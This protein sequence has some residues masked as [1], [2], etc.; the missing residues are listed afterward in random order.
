MD[1][2]IDY[3]AQMFSLYNLRADSALTHTHTHTHTHKETYWPC[4]YIWTHTHI[5]RHKHWLSFA[6][7]IRHIHTC[8]SAFSLLGWM[9]SD[10][11]IHNASC[12]IHSINKDDRSVSFFRGGGWVGGSSWCINILPK[13]HI[14]SSERHW[15]ATQHNFVVRSGYYS[16]LSGI[17]S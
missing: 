3:L 10:A 9:M 6:G 4:S 14:H 11:V 13:Y 7:T 1:D 15:Y 16:E 17:A 5:N 12:I 2:V 8:D